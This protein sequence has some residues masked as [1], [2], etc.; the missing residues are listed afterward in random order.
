MKVEKEQNQTLWVTIVGLVLSFLLIIFSSLGWLPFNLPTFL[1]LSILT[2]VIA[3]RK[4]KTIFWLFI[5]FLPLENIIVSSEEIPFSFRPFQLVGAVLILAV[6]A[7]IFTKEKRFKSLF[8]DEK[9]KS[10]KFNIFDG[11]VFVFP[12]FSLLGTIHA[13]DKIASFK[14]SIIL[15]S[16]VALYFLGR[17]FL[18]RKKDQLSAVWFF[19]IGSIPVLTFGIYQAVAYRLDW[20]SFQVMDGRV[21]ASFTEPDWLGIYLLVVIAIIYWLKIAVFRSEKGK[22]RSGDFLV[23]HKKMMIGK[24]SLFSVVKF[25]LNKFLLFSVLVLLLT[26]ARSAWLGF[27]LITILYFAILFWTSWKE[28]VK[29]Y[30][31]KIVFE[32]LLILILLLLSIV[33]IETTKISTFHFVNRATSSVSG[34]QKITVSCKEGAVVPRNIK[35][36][37]D[38]ARF[39]CR[40]IDLEE[41]N[42]ERGAGREIK[43]VFRPDPNVEIRKDTYEKIWYEIRKHPF[44]GQGIGSSEKILGF[45]D[46]GFPLNASNIFLETWL[47]VGIGGLVV[48]V[49]LFFLPLYL[50]VKKICNYKLEKISLSFFVL[51]SLPALIIPNLFNS[52]LFLGFSWIVLA[53]VGL[54]VCGGNK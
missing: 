8:I 41:I 44:L 2:F 51:L 53:A 6:I 20:T 26:V 22:K 37:E 14:Q 33:V 23:G 34:V 13:L 21:N 36:V 39:S 47:S 10:C 18:T 38:L 30:F 31:K 15:F 25:E 42:S 27:T 11:L 7:L 54:I 24:W 4:P 45:D 50:A 5:V 19:L 35:S 43:I 46:R 40:H 32:G 17:T 49:S 9:T 29:K 1:F 16:F 48:L 3:L 52:G 28:K 12:F